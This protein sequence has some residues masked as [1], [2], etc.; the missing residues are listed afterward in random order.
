MVA[1]TPDYHV[2]VL[3]T[4]ASQHPFDATWDSVRPLREY[5][6][7]QVIRQRGQFRVRSAIL[8]ANCFTQDSQSLSKLSG[9]F[10][11]AINVPLSFVTASEIADLVQ[12]LAHEPQLRAAIDWRQIFCRGGLLEH[13]I[14]A[15]QVAAARDGRYPRGT[16]MGC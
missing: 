5:S 14:V 7:A 13:S 1:Q 6:E 9:D 2:L 12:T 4:K 3:D 10:L 11:A 16:P 8:V 15:Q